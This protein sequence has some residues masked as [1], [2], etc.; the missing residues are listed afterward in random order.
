[1]QQRWSV[2]GIGVSA[3]LSRSLKVLGIAAFLTCG[4]IARVDAQVVNPADKQPATNEPQDQA[5]ATVD[6]HHTW[7]M[8]PVT[9]YGQAP[10]HEE[11]RIGDYA[12]P[13]WT[14]HRRF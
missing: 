10:L 6:D 2:K 9:V 7:T 1:M 4:P 12:Q 5:Q 11:D 3:R 14:A 13:R 8:P